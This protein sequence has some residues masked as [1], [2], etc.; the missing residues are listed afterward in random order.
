MT[1]ELWTAKGRE[2]QARVDTVDNFVEDV[3]THFHT[4][5]QRKRYRE[6]RE[7]PEFVD[8]GGES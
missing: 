2:C 3:F 8:L 6:E 5:V 1:V 7:H 4:K